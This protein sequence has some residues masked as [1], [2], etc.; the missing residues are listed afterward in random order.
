MDE[1]VVKEILDDLFSSLEALDTRCQAVL[2][3]LK[4]KGIGTEEDLAPY[5]K[6]AS[7]ASSVRWLATRVRI[8]HLLSGAAKQEEREKS[9]SEKAPEAKTGEDKESEAQA[10]PKS[11]I[12]RNKEDKA[13]SAPAP[14]FVKENVAVSKAPE[15]KP[16]KDKGAEVKA[17]S[18][19]PVTKAETR[20]E[21]PPEDSKLDQSSEKPDQGATKQDQNATKDAA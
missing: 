21:K 3:F 16:G 7:N 14:N 6:E 4:A 5:V 12:E 11:R 9:K 15:Q 18:A 1:Q 17:E 10:A 19:E 8:E 20:A 13:R 2:D